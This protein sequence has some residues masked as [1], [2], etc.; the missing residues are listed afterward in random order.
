MPSVTQ[1][2]ETQFVRA[3]DVHWVE[4][5]KVVTDL[6]LMTDVVQN[7]EYEDTQHIK[8]GRLRRGCHVSGG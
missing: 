2:L 5:V 7:V 4:S 6:R 8:G 3:G 1:R